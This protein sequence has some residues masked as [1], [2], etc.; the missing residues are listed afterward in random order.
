MDTILVQVFLFKFKAQTMSNYGT[1]ASL[2]VP[3]SLEFDVDVDDDGISYFVGSLF[4]GDQEEGQDIRVETDAVVESLC[5]YYSDVDGYNHLYVVAHELSRIAEI[6]R[7]R[8]GHVEDSVLATNDLFD[9][10]DEDW[11]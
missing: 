5:D 4:V 2:T 1:D 6:L 3:I 8:A 11:D 10:S 7:D 9:L